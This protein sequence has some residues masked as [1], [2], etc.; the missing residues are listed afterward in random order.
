[1]PKPETALPPCP[2]DRCETLEVIAGVLRRG[3]LYE[4]DED[5]TAWLA[6]VEVVEGLER[7]GFAVARSA[8]ASAPDATP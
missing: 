3:V 4:P 5:L 8:T 2:A 1:M 6:G 7:A